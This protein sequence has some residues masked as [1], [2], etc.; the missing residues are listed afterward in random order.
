MLEEMFCVGV[1]MQL[2]LDYRA[3]NEALLRATRIKIS[4][5]VLLTA[6]RSVCQNNVDELKG[7]PS[8]SFRKRETATTKI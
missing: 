6:A 7:I 3:K 5:E 2:V 8:F 1:N 4:S